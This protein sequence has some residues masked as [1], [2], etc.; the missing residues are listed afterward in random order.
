[1][2]KKSLKIFLIAGFLGSLVGLGGGIIL[3]PTWMAYGLPNQRT[4]ATS[5]FTVI[6]TSFSIVITNLI[7]GNYQFWEVIFWSALSFVG[8]EGVCLLLAY[9]VAKYRRESIILAVLL[10]AMYLSVALILFIG[11]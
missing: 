4:T 2:L 11:I 1:M 5:T 10:T 6:F 3:A 9:M 8:G 7:A